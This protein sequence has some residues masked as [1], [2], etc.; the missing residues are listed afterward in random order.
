MSSP[1]ERQRANH[2]PANEFRDW[3]HLPA[4]LLH[5]IS[6]KISSFT[7]YISIRAVCVS[8][9]LAFFPGPSHQPPPLFPWLMLPYDPDP[10]AGN[11]TSLRLFYD[12]VSCRTFKF[13]L[14]ETSRKRVVGSSHGWL[15]IEDGPNVSLVNPITK[16]V[17][18][19]PSF[20]TPPNILHYPPLEENLSPHT[21]DVLSRLTYDTGEPNI[22]NVIL[23]SHPSFDPCCIVM[24]LVRYW[25]LVFCRVGD[26]CWTVLG[27]DQTQEHRDEIG[28]AVLGVTY[29]DGLFYSINRYGKVVAYD[30]KGCKKEII[31]SEAPI[32]SNHCYSHCYLVASASG[33]L[34]MLS[35]HH[36]RSERSGI[37][38]YKLTRDGGKGKW[39]E[40]NDIGEI[41]VFVDCSCQCFP[42]PVNAFRSGPIGDR[43]EGNRLF[44]PYNSKAVCGNEDGYLFNVAIKSVNVGDLSFEKIN[45]NLGVF[46]STWTKSMWFTPS[47]C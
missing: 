14:P 25:K 42:L 15:V 12:P 29:H 10:C 26:E 18:R 19:L 47:L 11:D 30:L 9:R 36:N 2:P 3:S 44:H 17:I 1:K 41:V 39:E 40:T 7:D 6:D 20:T 38:A 4:E 33:E 34:L 24:V 13:N 31:D 22:F 16:A 27:G 32:Q 45:P 28:E 5:L 43:M 21:P 46:H 37:I 35:D 8:W 23:T